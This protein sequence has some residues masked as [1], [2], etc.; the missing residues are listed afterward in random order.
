MAHTELTA[1]G[2]WI[3]MPGPSPIKDDKS[4]LLL[5]SKQAIDYGIASGKADSANA[6]GQPSCGY[7]VVA[8]L[9]P[10]VGERIVEFLNGARS[11]RGF[12]ITIFFLA[13]YMIF[14]AP[15]QVAWAKSSASF[16]LGPH[17]R[18]PHAH[19]LRPVVGNPHHLPWPS[20]DRF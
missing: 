11:S 15:G 12:L 13:L 16:R 4:L 5:T 20:P 19:R 10:G 14:H 7:D 9:T 6:A 17:A 8:D 2:K 18:H 1:D 3:D